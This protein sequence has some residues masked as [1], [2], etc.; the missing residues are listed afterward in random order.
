M[1]FLDS[2]DSSNK[3]P[4]ANDISDGGS[5]DVQ[6][7]P[8][9]TTVQNIDLPVQQ[10]NSEPVESSSQD[11]CSV[12][13]SAAVL[14][15]GGLRASRATYGRQRSFLNEAS[16][17]GHI[18]DE[19]DSHYRKQRQTVPESTPHVDFHTDD[20]MGN[21]IGPVRSI[22]ELRQAGDN[23]RFRG[24]VDGIFEEIA[25]SHDSASA[26]CN[27][28]VQLSSR[29]LDRRFSRRFCESG[30]VEKFVECLTNDL[31]LISASFALCSYELIHTSGTFSPTHWARLWP[32]LL[33]LSSILLDA[34]NDI[35]H[36]SK[37]R[38]FGISKSV[39]ISIQRTIPVL[40]SVIGGD[41]PLS[42]LSPCLI[43]LRSL[44][45]CLL[46]VRQNNNNIEPINAAT[47]KQLVNMVLLKNP[48][49]LMSPED[50]QVVRWVLSILEAYMTFSSS[51]SVEHQDALRPITRLYH[52]LDL[53]KSEFND[54]SQEIRVL[55]IKVILNLTNNDSSFWTEF[56]KPE[57]VG[58][59]VRIVL[60]KFCVLTDERLVQEKNSMD[61]IILALGTLINL[62]QRSDLAR[63]M[64]L[65]TTKN[66][67]PLL[68]L[69][70]QQ[71]SAANIDL[72]TEVCQFFIIFMLFLDIQH[73][74]I[75]LS[76]YIISLIYDPYFHHF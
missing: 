24:A 71:F 11:T 60:S 68:Q 54:Q 30:F 52:L 64:F 9:I 51:L 38:I 2:V 65:T 1:D 10:L 28:F 67:T 32:K 66:S 73:P 12:E 41:L 45:S 7:P 37:R 26:R 17:P 61:T 59:L 35:Y 27:G 47:L 13:D 40:S 25:A 31:D 42:T 5:N 18:E 72:V 39:Q 63:T 44:Y 69:L 16:V 29:L 76:S 21:G 3:G 22:H 58:T 20:D 46:A 14:P 36:L 33:D 6:Y 62:T 49:P 34:E 57:L 19:N 56:V 43:A 75:P 4:P 48:G 74:F 8:D 23:A 70:L 50:F 15:S 55:Y 53:D